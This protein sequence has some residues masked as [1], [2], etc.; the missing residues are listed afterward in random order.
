MLCCMCSCCSIFFVCF[1]M[2]VLLVI[3]M[4]IMC[5]E[6][7]WVMKESKVLWL[8]GV[9]FL[10]IVWLIVCSVCLSVF[11]LCLGVRWWMCVVLL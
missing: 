10:L 5:C 11:L 1:V 9:V 8:F 4:M 3:I 2:G 7:V 6:M